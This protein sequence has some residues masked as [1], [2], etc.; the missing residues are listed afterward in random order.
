MLLL[1]GFNNI[2]TEVSKQKKLNNINSESYYTNCSKQLE[3]IPCPNCHED[4]G[5]FKGFYYIGCI[6]CFNL[7][8]TDTELVNKLTK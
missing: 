3:H 7:Y 2:F 4:H 8:L 6:N 5:L 1:L